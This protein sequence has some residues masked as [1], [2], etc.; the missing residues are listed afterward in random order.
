MKGKKI[1]ALCL[2][3]TATISS[4]SAC[5]LGETGEHVHEWSK[6]YTAKEATCTEDGI[7]EAICECGE[8]NYQTLLSVGHKYKNGA[9]SVCGELENV[10]AEEPND[11]SQIIEISAGKELGFSLNDLYDIYC[12]FGQ[13]GSLEF[14]KKELVNVNS[15]L[16]ELYVG[17]LGELHLTLTNN[18]YKTEG[19]IILGDIREEFP[20][21]VK[22]SILRQIYFKVSNQ[23][24]QD[25]DFVVLD[26]DGTERVIGA[27]SK[28][29]SIAVTKQNYVLVCFNDSTA[30]VA[31]LLPINNAL[32]SSTA[33]LVYHKEENNEYTV[34]GMID[35]TQSSVEIP[36]T[37]R[38]VPVT[39]IVSYAFSECNN[40]QSVVIWDNVKHI[41]N[42]AF[43]GCTLLTS[44]E[45]KA[46][47]GWDTRLQ[48]AQTAA[49]ILKTSNMEWF[50]S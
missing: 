27:Y 18:G 50:R 17:K 38:G 4:F 14:F 20:L 35:Q 48:D 37:H 10:D 7:L 29:K 9:C 47:S 22:T 19:S 49:Q 3:I 40:L 6:F 26:A 25:Y 12:D 5:G 45:F 32:P 11:D 21:N 30:K 13:T 8:K 28:I 39:N 43:Y 31:G 16:S 24:S 36:L 41:G 1:T 2:A 34:I 46:S 42:S 23:N 44:V 33:N 15:C